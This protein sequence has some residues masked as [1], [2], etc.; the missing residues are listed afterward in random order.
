MCVCEWCVCECTRGC[1]CVFVG[2]NG[3]VGYGANVSRELCT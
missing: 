3:S 1:V 2:G